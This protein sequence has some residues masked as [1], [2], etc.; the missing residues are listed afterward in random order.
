MDPPDAE[1]RA[2][3]GPATPET[4]AALEA[5][6][7]RYPLSATL[8]VLAAGAAL[9]SRPH[10]IATARRLYAEAQAMQERGCRLPARIDWSMV[11]GQALSH[12]FEGDF[13]GALPYLQQGA[14]RFPNETSIHYNLACAYCMTGNLDGCHAAFAETLAIAARG[15]HPPWTDDVQTVGHY[16]RLSARDS[17]LTTL[18]ADPRYAATVAPYQDAP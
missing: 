9:H 17:D 13:A 11:L 18:R 1:I 14:P 10:D 3:Q 16:V 15:G 12:Q 7:Q 5:L 4:V 6:G 8:R 2:A